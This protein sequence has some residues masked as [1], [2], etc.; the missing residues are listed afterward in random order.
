[1]GTETNTTQLINDPPEAA[2]AE[3][4][5]GGDIITVANTDTTIGVQERPALTAEEALMESEG[6]SELVEQLE[7][8]IDPVFKY[9]LQVAAGK[10]KSRTYLPTSVEAYQETKYVVGQDPT[11]VPEGCTVHKQVSILYKVKENS[12]HVGKVDYVMVDSE[13]QVV[14]VGARSKDTLDVFAENIFGRNV[15]AADLSRLYSLNEKLMDALRANPECAVKLNEFNTKRKQEVAW[16]DRATLAYYEPDRFNI[17]EWANANGFSQREL[18]KAGFLERTVTE[19][20]VSYSARTKPVVFIPFKDED[21]RLVLWRMRV[22]KPK[23]PGDPKYLSAPLERADR[24]PPSVHRE[25]YQSELLKDIK[26]KPLI[27]TEGEFK[28]LVTTQLTGISTVGITGITQVTDLII[29]KIVEA[30]PSQITVILDRDPKGKGFARTDELTDSER[31]AFMIA[32]RLQRAGHG[33]VRIGTIPDH[34]N[35]DKCGIDDFLLDIHEKSKQGAPKEALEEVLHE[36]LPPRQWLSSRSNDPDLQELVARIQRL[37]QVHRDF[38]SHLIRSGEY[39]IG[40]E[41]RHEAESKLVDVQAMLDMLIAAQRRHLNEHYNGARRINQPPRKFL[42]L[43][44]AASIRDHERKCLV[45]QDGV[46]IPLDHFKEPILSLRATPPDL[47]NADKLV[48]AEGDSFPISMAKLSKAYLHP[49]PETD[50][51]KLYERGRD[52]LAPGAKESLWTKE[53][54]SY[55]VFI[56]RVFAGWLATRYPPSEYRYEEKVSL[57][58]VHRTHWE[59]IVRVPITIFKD[60]EKPVAFCFLPY[61]NTRDAEVSTVR[62]VSADKQEHELKQMAV[63]NLARNSALAESRSRAAIRSFLRNPKLEDQLEKLNQI[64]GALARV[65]GDAGKTGAVEYMKTLGI[66]EEVAAE[67]GAILLAKKQRANL[68]SQLGLE[69]LINQGIQSGLLWPPEGGFAEA[70][71]SGDVVLIPE[72]GEDGRC[73]GFSVLPVDN[74]DRRLKRFP[75]IP[76][77]IYPLDSIRSTTRA[78]DRTRTLFPRISHTELKD[79]TVLIAPSEL[80]CLQLRSLVVNLQMQDVVVLGIRELDSISR[81]EYKSLAGAGPKRVIFVGS[82]TQRESLALRYAPLA[83]SEPATHAASYIRANKGVPAVPPVS[84]LQLSTDLSEVLTELTK[85]QDVAK[86][87][88]SDVLSQKIFVPDERTLAKLIFSEL[89]ADIEAAVAMRGKSKDSTEVPLSFEFRDA[90]DMLRVLYELAR[91]GDGSLEDFL[92]DRYLIPREQALE[93]LM[94]GFDKPLYRPGSIVTTKI[95]KFMWDDY[96]SAENAVNRLQERAGLD[97]NGDVLSSAL[98]AVSLNQKTEQLNLEGVSDILQQLVSKKVCTLQKPVHTTKTVLGRNCFQTSLSLT[99]EGRILTAHGSGLSKKTAEADALTN[100]YQIVSEDQELGDVYRREEATS[101][102]RIDFERRL[103]NRKCFASLNREVKL[104][105]SQSVPIELITGQQERA[106][107]NSG[108]V[109]PLTLKIFDEEYSYSFKGSNP[110]ASQNMAAARLIV[111]IREVLR[112]KRETGEYSD[113]TTTVANLEYLAELLDVSLQKEQP[114]V[115]EAEHAPDVEQEEIGSPQQHIRHH[116]EKKFLCQWSFTIDGAAVVETGS[117]KKK[118]HAER[119]VAAKLLR[120]LEQYDPVLEILTW[121]KESTSSS[122]P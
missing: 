37:R 71:F 81:S 32:E 38:S 107:D 106:K 74:T 39:P 50:I 12:R 98:T 115:I 55:E 95:P 87:F 97:F 52:I 46:V 80:E 75:P 86:G 110:G 24:Y 118:A 88:L 25:L 93:K 84:I 60:G 48:G 78:F 3:L 85:N 58:K 9:S 14:E 8:Q 59:D 122:E 4:H 109:V 119:D 33:N 96:L 40:S 6:W 13:G 113:P 101:K 53:K 121:E 91:D 66:S 68:V 82:A 99:F 36:G 70:R 26:G 47:G 77:K 116:K 23:N 43:Y 76:K 22:I 83:L 30:G 19:T 20:G 35:G 90:V 105:R 61:W 62:R 34:F 92:S 42:T 103:R 79:K 31:A 94:S 17:I 104:L 89:L 111:C 45:T 28:C 54:H 117:G 108:W 7:P 51:A 10:G 65:C 1:M 15:T 64:A 63:A 11:E 16:S 67:C 57:R 41:G 21:G 120:Q 69:D 18:Y 100:L 44:P 56:Q 112:Q 5:A 73:V 2:T 29:Q 49:R 72:R 114:V 102:T 27:I